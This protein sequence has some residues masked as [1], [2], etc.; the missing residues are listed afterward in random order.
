MFYKTF[1]RWMGIMLEGNVRNGCHAQ[2]I[3]R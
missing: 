3:V 1:I 2:P